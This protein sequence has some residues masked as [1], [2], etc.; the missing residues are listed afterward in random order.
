M[1]TAA[2][3]LNAN[4]I[5]LKRHVDGNQKSTCPRCSHNRRNKRE[6]CLSVEIGRLGVRFNCH[7]CGFSGGEF[8]DS[9]NQP[10]ARPAR[11]PK[12]K[13]DLKDFYR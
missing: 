5:I 2:E 13:R 8:Y 6:P 3:I 11:S 12:P 7:H 1:K 4:G 9:G 10:I